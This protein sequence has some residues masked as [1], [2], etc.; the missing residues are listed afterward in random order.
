MYHQKYKTHTD[1]NWQL[2][3]YNMFTWP[4]LFYICF[5][6]SDAKKLSSNIFLAFFC[7]IA[8]WFYVRLNATQ[9]A[10]CFL[11]FFVLR[12]PHKTLYMHWFNQHYMTSFSTTIQPGRIL[13]DE[14]LFERIIFSLIFFNDTNCRA[15]WQCLIL[16]LYRYLGWFLKKKSL[17]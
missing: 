3:N 10:Y 12:R 6:H 4:V 1:D 16:I 11:I 2:Y 14:I 5:C 15:K 13:N 8:V 17:R 9:N 7:T